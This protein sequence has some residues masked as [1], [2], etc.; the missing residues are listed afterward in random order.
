MPNADAALISDPARLA[1]LYQLDLISNGPIPAFDRLTRLA[2]QILNVPVALVTLVAGDRQYFLSQ[3]GVGEPYAS[4]GGTPISHSYC[5]HAVVSQQPLIIPDAHAHP[6]VYDNPALQELDAVAYAGIPL[7]IEDGHVLGTLCVLD[8]QARAWTD[9]EIAILADLTQFVLTEIALREELAVRQRLEAQIRKD[10][11][12]IRQVINAIPML[13]YLYDLD[14]DELVYS[15]APG[16]RFLGYERG[17]RLDEVLTQDDVNAIFAAARSLVSPVTPPDQL[18]DMELSATHADTRTGYV[19]LLMKAF[20][21]EADSPTRQVLGVAEDVS[22]YRQAEQ[23]ALEFKLRAARLQMLHT[24]IENASHDLRT[25][26]TIIQTNA[27][28]LSKGAQTEDR[29]R[30]RVEK[31]D[32]QVRKISHTI[33]DFLALVRLDQTPALQVAD[34]AVNALLLSTLHLLRTHFTATPR[35]V[36]QLAAALPSIRADSAL[37]QQAFYAV[38]ENA[39]HYTPLDG[40]I[41]VRTL[42]EPGFIVVEIEDTGQGI[43]AADRPLIFQP[44]FKGN[45][46]RS[47]DAGRSGM[48]LAI[49]ER[50]IALHSGTIE[51]DPNVTTGTIIRMCLPL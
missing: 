15:S 27:Y 38:L 19:R 41:R 10:E 48:G 21:G 3:V 35:I 1:A 14:R 17:I 9:Q 29:M 18:I 36:E 30:Q 46:T 24:F 47:N 28:L 33:E 31:I 22:D 12:F 50:I 32:E 34:V 51:A 16:G 23:T 8:H 6:L 37:L 40:E 43:D 49:A 39:V 11:Q 20:V 5:Q 26:L 13:I 7:T 44:M 4:Q 2:S 42:P 25:P 45:R